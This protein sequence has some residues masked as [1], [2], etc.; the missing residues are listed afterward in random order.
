MHDAWQV[1]ICFLNLNNEDN[2]FFFSPTSVP[3]KEKDIFKIYFAKSSAN[4]SG[5]GGKVSNGSNKGQPL[6]QERLQ[7]TRLQPL[8][9]A[10][11]EGQWASFSLCIDWIPCGHVCHLKHCYLAHAVCE[12]C[13]FHVYQEGKRLHVWHIIRMILVGTKTVYWT[14]IGKWSHIDWNAQ[15][16]PILF[17]TV[18]YLHWAEI[19]DLWLYKKWFAKWM[20]LGWAGQ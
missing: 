5:K 19:S 3:G 20:D 16:Y 10:V 7:Q 6:S 17:F 14:H 1:N 15:T 11:E 2:S 8:S 9:A 12:A 4:A 13:L 18:T